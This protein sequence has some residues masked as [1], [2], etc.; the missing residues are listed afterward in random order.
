MLKKTLQTIT[1][2]D[3]QHDRFDHILSLAKASGFDALEIGYRRLSQ[4]SV[5]EMQT[6]LDK[7]QLTLS[8]THIG[9][10]LEDMK[11][12][13]EERNG[14]AR[15]LGEVKQLGARNIMYSGLNEKSKEAIETGIDQLNEAASICAEQGL[16]L[17]YHNHGWEFADGGWIFQRL[18]EKASDQIGFGLDVGW[19]LYAGE[20]VTK[21]LNDLS[22]RIHILHI[23][24]YDRLGEGFHTVHLGTGVLQLEPVWQWIAQQKDRDVF[25]TAEQDSAPDADL[26]CRENGAYLSQ[27]FEALGL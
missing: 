22:D 24:D 20:D 12:A 26:A 11:Q 4:V 6:L 13:G 2:G 15:V 16:Q 14:L 5:E 9:G 3:P 17:L 1:W 23:K 10:N 7:H 8:S 19:A 21:L 27:Q 18:L 25:I